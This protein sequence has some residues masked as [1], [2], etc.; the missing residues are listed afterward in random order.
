MQPRGIRQKDAF[1]CSFTP[2]KC[3]NTNCHSIVD[4]GVL[5]CSAECAEAK[6]IVKKGRVIR[7]DKIRS[8]KHRFSPEE[9]ARRLLEAKELERLFYKARINHYANK[10]RAAKLQR[11]PSWA[12]LSAIQRM[13]VEA[14]RK[15]RKTGI[16]HHVDH[17]IPL[18]GKTVCGL[19]VANN[20][21]VL[22]ASENGRKYNKLIEV[23]D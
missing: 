14:R 10:R 6:P 11:T 4:D 2:R 21:Q 22:T 13:Y 18:Q 16:D 19:H 3:K 9:R 1:P 5:Y 15:T 17:V 20:L 8:H 23:Y 7:L 12:D